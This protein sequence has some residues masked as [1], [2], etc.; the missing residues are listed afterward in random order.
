MR[1]LRLPLVFLA[2]L[3]A[4]RAGALEPGRAPRPDWSDWGPAA[5][6]RAAAEHK[7]VLLDLHAVWCH[8]CHVME[9]TTYQDPRVVRLLA[10][11]FVVVSVDQ[12]A[13]P[14]LS[15]RY[16]DWGWPA[17]ILFAPDGTELAKRAGYVE[18]GSM[19]ELLES[20]L[21]DPTPRNQTRPEH[22]PRTSAAGAAADLRAA[23]E[24]REAELY[25]EQ[26]AGFGHGGHKY[27]DAASCERLLRAAL[28]GSGQAR[29]RARATLQATRALLDPVWGGIYQ[30]S[31]GGDWHEP[32]FEKLMSFQS[33][34]L[35]TYALA[36]RVLGDT[37]WLEDAGS[38]ARYLETF[39]RE[40]DGAYYASQDADRVPGEHSAAYFALDDAARRER[41]IP[42][43]DRHVYARE[44]GW[45]IRGL[46]ALFN[47]GGDERVL[48]GARRTAQLM[49][50][51]R[52]LPGG[53]FRHD[54]HDP[55]GPYLAD[56]LAMAQAFLA[57]HE[58]TAE[59]VWLAHALECSEFLA[60]NFASGAQEAG[61]ATAAAGADS[62]RL[63]P[64]APQR[65]ENA[66]LCRLEIAL[67]H[68]SG[69]ERHRR[70][71]ERA[72]AW[73]MREPV[74][75]RGLPACVLLA[76]EELGAEPVHV[77]VVGSK[78]DPAARELYRAALAAP[79]AVRRLEW[80]DRAE[81][82][83]PRADVE[84]PELDRAAAFV[85]SAGRCSA[86]AFE[87]LE[88]R[89]RLARQPR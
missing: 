49:L 22:A 76:L 19:R 34:A 29:G 53:G 28:A 77:T 30:Y 70:R 32:H 16:E 85:C 67:L 71:A 80:Y 33:E 27:L 68:A 66:A 62:V 15:A 65:E 83:L 39:L 82:A 69:D 25:D 23:L 55:A 42:R 41:G 3:G 52:A 10:Q 54:E 81:G 74:A 26:H 50:E 24:A 84:Y 88:L 2:L 89:T 78:R 51:R 6:E 14:D 57:L 35:S 59:R 13:R 4:C 5:F 1:L 87:A 64:P 45:A 44:N 47:A 61:Y 21:A 40:P 48:E 73:L 38:V 56:T 36:A 37:T 11:H 8:W 79:L 46:C 75:L 12:D 31:V 7:L 58:S 43:V 72:Q 18:P 20:V 17:T 63:G 60:A 86:P 9:A